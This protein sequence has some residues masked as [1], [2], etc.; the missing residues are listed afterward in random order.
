M[1]YNVSA[2]PCTYIGTYKSGMLRLHI[3]RNRRTCVGKTII[4]K[5]PL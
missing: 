4:V 3:S 2:I 5:K 1:M